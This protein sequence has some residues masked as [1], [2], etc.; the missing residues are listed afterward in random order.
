LLS[1]DVRHL[2]ATAF[3]S[4]ESADRLAFEN[5]L[6][7]MADGLTGRGILRSGVLTLEVTTLADD[8]CRKQYKAAGDALIRACQSK[9][10]RPY[11]QMV[12]DLVAEAAKFGDQSKARIETRAV[13]AVKLAPN[14]VGA[15]SQIKGNL[16]S[17][18]LQGKLAARSEIEHYVAS[19]TRTRREAL[20][21]M[22]WDAIKVLAGAAVGAIATE[23]FHAAADRFAARSAVPT[24]TQ[25]ATV[26]SRH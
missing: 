24:S 3:A 21:T 8:Y 25:S 7:A 4:A 2:A 14:P 17:A 6:G 5:A 18:S 9:G 26:R 13:Q 23:A 1:E 19:L 12:D 22:R 16:L 15:S 20:A 10:L 11:Q